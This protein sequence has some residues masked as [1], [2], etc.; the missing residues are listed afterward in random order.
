MTESREPEV[1][2]LVIGAGPVGLTMACELRWQGVSCRILDQRAEPT[3]LVESR[4]LGVQARTLE[5]FRSLGVADRALA[6]GHKVHGLNAYADGLRILHLGLDL[7]DL[8]TPYP[9]ILVLPQGYTERLLADRLTTLGGAVERGTSLDRIA[10]DESGVTATVWD[11]AGVRSEIRAGWVVGC[12]GARSAVRRE[13][14]LA[15]AGSEYEERFLLADLHVGW[16]M[17]RDEAIILL[18]PEGPLLAFPL[19]EGRWRLID[20]TGMVDSDEP[21]QIV[22]RFRELVRRHAQPDAVVD[23]AVWTSSFHLHRRVVDRF[24]VGRCFVAGDAA[25]LHSP[26]G[27]QGMN[28]G[29][30]DAANLAWKL[31]L[32]CRGQAGPGLLDSYEAERRPVAQ[33]VL[34]GSDVATR[35]IALRGEVSRGLRNSLLGFLSEFDFVRR[36]VSMEMSE[37]SIGYRGSPVVAEDRSGVLHAVLPHAHQAGEAGVVDTLDFAVA[38]RPGDR[39]PDVPR[40]E[41]EGAPERLLDAFSGTQ[42]TLLLFPGTHPDSDAAPLAEAGELA[43]RGHAG[44]VRTLWVSADGTA[45]AWADAAWADRD[46]A[47]ARR[48]GAGAPCLYLVRPDGYIGYRAQPPDA[49]RLGAYL[50]RLFTPAGA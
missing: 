37:L 9:F 39:A 29:I 1:D 31:A 23:D 35:M 26:A 27:G 10:Q 12:D 49:A 17:P 16:A 3:P 46:G 19:P 18:T 38:P 32:A 45:P 2:V 7:D 41:G 25:H 44:L 47:A 34:R 15:F 22:A 28:T 30:Q 42:H 40:I 43:R 50:D 36:R 48:Y 21:A 8:D 14:E 4:A 24:R 5:V 20:T 33:A 11:G 13:L 6:E